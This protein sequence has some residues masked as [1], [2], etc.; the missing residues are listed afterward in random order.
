MSVANTTN[1]LLPYEP[2][3][4]AEEHPPIFLK[5]NEATLELLKSSIMEQNKQPSIILSMSDRTASLKINNYEFQ[6]SHYR[7]PGSVQIFAP[8]DHSISDRPP[9]TFRSKGFVQDRVAIKQDKPHKIPTS[10]NEVDLTQPT[11]SKMISLLAT[12]PHTANELCSKTQASSNLVNSVLKN[13]AIPVS[14]G[15]EQHKLKPGIQATSKRERTPPKIDSCPSSR[16]ASSNKSD[17]SKADDVDGN[18]TNDA[19]GEPNYDLADTTKAR[20][21]GTA[22]DDKVLE[23]SALKRKLKLNSI[24]SK[25]VRLM[26]ASSEDMFELARKFREVYDEYRELYSKLSNPRARP[27]SQVQRLITMHR[28]LGQWKKTLW[29]NSSSKQVK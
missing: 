6:G 9:R 21:N 3:E 23:S 1:T 11:G 25:R 10:T 14:E 4:S 24:D 19:I 17:S 18:F 22:H 8:E 16:T 7:E 15:S 20:R 27:P 29:S 5:I 28:Q 2:P 13:A 12:K 26:E